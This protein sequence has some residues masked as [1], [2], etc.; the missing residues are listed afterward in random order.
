MELLWLICKGT[1]LVTVTLFFLTVLYAVISTLI[2]NI[3]RDCK[4]IKKYEQ[5]K[6]DYQELLEKVQRLEVELIDKELEIDYTKLKLNK[7]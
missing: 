3:L 6:K 4:N 5:L 1:V 7:N 2:Q